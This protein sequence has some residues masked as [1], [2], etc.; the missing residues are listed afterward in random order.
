MSVTGAGDGSTAPETTEVEQTSDAPW[1]ADLRGLGLDD[2]TFTKVDGYMREKV[3]PHTTKL[4]QDVSELREAVPEGLQQFWADLGEDPDQALTSLASEVYSDNPE[5]AEIFEVA[6]KYATGHPEASNE[7]V[8]AAAS[9]HVEAGGT[10][11]DFEVELDPEDRALLDDVQ[12]ERED[13]A[14][15]EELLALKEANPDHFP[16]NWGE[17]ELVRVMS[18][19]V[20][21]APEEL[22]DEQAMEYA[23]ESYRNAYALIHGGEPG[24]E[25][26]AANAAASLSPKQIAAINAQAPPTLTGGQNSSVPSEKQYESIGEAV[27]DFG[28]E[29]AAKRAAPPVV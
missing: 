22:D 18:P 27:Q 13:D 11:E 7:E 3:Q 17:D 29:M 6:I 20:V 26:A 21:A 15:A 23:F 1:A 16:E 24:T 9:E 4:E 28:R 2:E 8:V 14:Y 10:A 25:E 19:F 12:A 5:A